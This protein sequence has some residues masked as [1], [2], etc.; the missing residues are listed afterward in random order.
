MFFGEILNSYVKDSSI[1]SDTSSLLATNT[2]PQW[3]GRYVHWFSVSL[4]LVIVI[5]VVTGSSERFGALVKL[6][7]VSKGELL[8]VTLGGGSPILVLSEE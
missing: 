6:A 2:K 3:R 7:V 8:M 4:T 1:T 5:S